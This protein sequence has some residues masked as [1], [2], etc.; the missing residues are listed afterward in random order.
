MK[1]V[2]SFWSKPFLGNSTG[3]LLSRN[4]GGWLNSK[5][6]YMS[7]ALSCLQLRK[8][9]PDMNLELVTDSFGKKLLINRLKLPYDQVHLELDPLSRFSESLWAIGKIKTYSIQSSPF[10]H[11]DGDVFIW[12][13]VLSNLFKSDLCVQSIDRQARYYARTSKKIIDLFGYIPDDLLD[14]LKSKQIFGVNAGVIGGSN[15]EFFKNYTSFAMSFV[16]KNIGALKY[17]DQEYFNMFYE[18]FLFSFWQRKNK[19]KLTTL[20]DNL[21]ADFNEIVDMTMIPI[22]KYNH[23]VGLAKSNI[24]INEQVCLRLAIDYPVYYERINNMDFG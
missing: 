20:F 13:D 8:I 3:S 21:S 11:V 16:N 18:Q 17:L 7:W 5:C 6:F 22:Q 2:Q 24:I 4:N 15:I 14:H 23:I 19:L 1:L 12:D 9:Y 10:I